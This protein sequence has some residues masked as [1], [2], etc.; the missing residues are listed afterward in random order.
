MVVFADTFLVKRDPEL[1][2]PIKCL[3][4]FLGSQSNQSQIARIFSRD[5]AT[6]YPSL[7]EELNVEN[8]QTPTVVITL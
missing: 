7:K 3:S 6:E 2:I 1:I 5:F 4:K 8:K